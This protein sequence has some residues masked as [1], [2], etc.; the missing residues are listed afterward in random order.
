MRRAYGSAPAC[1]P[2]SVKPRSA[3]G[4]GA[5]LLD[6]ALASVGCELADV[7]DGGDHAIV[8]GRVTSGGPTGVCRAARARPARLPARRCRRA[9]RPRGRAR[10]RSTARPT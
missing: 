1:Q 7:L 4:T 8:L 5:P 9:W 10:R 3:A 6:G 2:D